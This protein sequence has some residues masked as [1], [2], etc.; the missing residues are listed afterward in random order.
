MFDKVLVFVVF[1]IIIGL[2]VWRQMV[3]DIREKDL[4][5]RL[6]SKTVGEYAEATRRIRMPAP[7]SSIT[8]SEAIDRLAEEGISAEEAALSQRESDHV[9]IS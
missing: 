8:V 4:L 5:N 9:R 2:Y 3:F 6:M 1:L 7:V